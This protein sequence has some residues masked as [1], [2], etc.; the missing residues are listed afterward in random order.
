MVLDLK[1]TF[2]LCFL[3]SIIYLFLSVPCL[4]CCMGFSPV[5]V[6]RDYSGFW[7]KDFYGLYSPWGHKESDTT[8]RLY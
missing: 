5:V 7:N 8:K 4:H 2:D 1:E 6:S 3:Y